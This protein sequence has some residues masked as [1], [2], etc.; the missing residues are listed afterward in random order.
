MERSPPSSSGLALREPQGHR[1]QRKAVAASQHQVLLTG[2]AL[3]VSLPAVTSS[4][5]RSTTAPRRSALTWP[6]GARAGIDLRPES[7]FQARDLGATSGPHP[8]RQQR[9]TPGNGGHLTSQLD[10][11]SRPASQVVRLPRFSLAR[12]NPSRRP[13]RWQRQEPAST[14]APGRAERLPPQPRYDGKTGSDTD[15]CAAPVEPSTTARR[16]A[17]RRARARHWATGAWARVRNGGGGGVFG[18]ELGVAGR[19]ARRRPRRV[20]RPGGGAGRGGPGRRARS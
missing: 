5:Q 9:T 2:R 12:K 10:S 20:R 6:L 13:P 18:G 8:T 19:R 3:G 16:G 4:D 11:P 17:A 14:L 15:L 1:R 7:A